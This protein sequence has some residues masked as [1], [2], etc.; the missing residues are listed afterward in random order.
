MHQLSCIV[1]HLQFVEV[2]VCPIYHINSSVMVQSSSMS[3]FLI[4]LL[5][6]VKTLRNFD[7]MISCYLKSSLVRLECSAF[8]RN[9][10]AIHSCQVRANN[11]EHCLEQETIHTENFCD[12]D[13]IDCGG[14]YQ[15]NLIISL[16]PIQSNR[17]QNVLV[18]TK[19]I[20]LLSRYLLLVMPN[21]WTLRNIW[22][23]ECI[24]RGFLM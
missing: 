13:Y 18:I 1:E 22:I 8:R 6:G 11:T 2:S 9:V 24:F 17:K 15:K 4:C 14:D 5:S 21:I 19:N 10:Q 20:L 23:I 12:L 7:I 3:Y 16:I